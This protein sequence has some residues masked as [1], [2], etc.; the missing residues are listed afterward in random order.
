MKPIVVWYKNAMAIGNY[1]R[2]RLPGDMSD[3]PD[4]KPH[5][6][7]KE[8]LQM[9]IFEGKYLNSCRDEYPPDWF[10]GAPMSDT[11]D[12][13][14]NYF[15]LKTRLPLSWWLEKNLI[16]PEDPRGWFEWYCRFWMGR[17]IAD[18]ARQIKRWKQIAR[19]S[20]QV[21]KHGKGDPAVR[22]R[23]RQTLLQWSWDPYPDMK[24]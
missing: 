15:K 19:H 22:A 23:Q 1:T 10:E 8:M 12:E 21:K 7:P 18:D 11:P 20:G 9:G 16:Y 13:K 14:L 6:T 4:F 24:A 5:F 3:F 2:T 17:R